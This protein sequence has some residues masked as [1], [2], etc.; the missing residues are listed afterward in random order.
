MLNKSAAELALTKAVSTGGDFA[1]IFYEDTR[2]L[3]ITQ[4]DDKID[5]SST[6]RT[7][8]AGLRV[9]KG[10]NS[11][12]V[13]SNNTDAEGLMKMACDAADAI[14]SGEAAILNLN[15]VGS[16]TPNI[17]EIKK[18]AGDMP[19]SARSAVVRTACRAAA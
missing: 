16:V 18:L 19:G 15:L 12:Y 3:G 2:S 6:S 9:Y 8:G 5:S 7:H 10:L 13:H 11:V 1:E 4:V 14:G 17:H